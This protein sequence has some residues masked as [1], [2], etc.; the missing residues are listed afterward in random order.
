VTFQTRS[1]ETFSGHTRSNPQRRR[2]SSTGRP[3][4]PIAVPTTSAPRNDRRA[5]PTAIM[6]SAARLFY[7]SVFALWGSPIRCQ[8]SDS[9]SQDACAV[10]SL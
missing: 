2:T 9:P 4:A 6:K 3:C 5:A 10:C 7:L 1:R 8:N